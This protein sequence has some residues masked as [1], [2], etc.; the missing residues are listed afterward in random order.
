MTWNETSEAI[1]QLKARLCLLPAKTKENTIEYEKLA[2]PIRAEAI[3]IHYI[4]IELT[5]K[6]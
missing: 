3:R 6:A 5:M 1:D 4:R 2:K